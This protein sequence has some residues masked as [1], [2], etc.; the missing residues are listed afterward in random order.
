MSRR[1]ARSHARLAV[2]L[3]GSVLVPLIASACSSG[4]STSTPTASVTLALTDAVSDQVVRFEVDVSDVRL[5]QPDGRSV[6]VLDAPVRVDFADLATRFAILPPTEIPTGRY[7]EV[8]MVVDFTNADVVL[9]DRS[10][11]TTVVD[12]RGNLLNGPVPTRIDLR[13]EARPFAGGALPHLYALDLDLDQAVRVDA[14]RNRVVFSPVF[15]ASFDPVDPK[16]SIL[17]GIL[18]AVDPGAGRVAV[19]RLGADGVTPLK[20]LPVAVGATA[21]VQIDGRAVSAD[22][23]LA[24]LAPFAGTPVLVEGELRS[25]GTL[26]AS[27]LE[28]G[29]GAGLRDRIEGHVVARTVVRDDGTADITVRGRLVD[30][31]SGN[32]ERD[33]VVVLRVQRDAT[34]VVTRGRRASF[35]LDAVQVG[36]RVAAFGTIAGTQLDATS[37]NDGLVR[38]LPARVLATTTQSGP[39]G[40]TLAVQRIGMLP[41]TAFDFAVPGAPSL[42]PGALLA[43]LP[44]GFPTPPS[45]TRLELRGTFAATREHGLDG[46]P[47]QLGARPDERSADVVR[48]VGPAAGRRRAALPGS[49]ASRARARRQRGPGALRRDRNRDPARRRTPG[50]R[51]RLE[52]DRVPHRRRPHGRVA[53]HVRRLRDGPRCAARRGLGDRLGLDPR[54]SRRG[55]GRVRSRQRDGR[56]ALSDIAHAAH[57][58]AGAPPV[59][60]DRTAGLSDRGRRA[61]RV[62]ALRDPC[63]SACRHRHRRRVSR[64]RARPSSRRP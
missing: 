5:V 30:E 25:D 58:G 19:R 38:I 61:R 42:D 52:P 35:G 46:L 2:L 32:I 17:R 63:S 23:A 31:P 62:L 41:L 50:P 8:S 57:R 26:R 13:G 27:M 34:R 47:R 7:A 59:R 53:P 9:A 33:R 20:P 45:G 15:D 37:P 18:Q 39:N 49:C 24:Q 55:D 12:P 4:G 1:H 44:N 36:Q 10:R 6:P 54:C 51:R 48:R 56:P 21:I 11:P 22:T 3:A 60:V 64:A 28:A 40:T 14:A 43:T 16:P 29:L